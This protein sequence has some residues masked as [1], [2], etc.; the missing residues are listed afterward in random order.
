MPIN[1]DDHFANG[2]RTKKDEN[3][4]PMGSAPVQSATERR[5]RSLIAKLSGSAFTKEP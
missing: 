3:I 4:N 2:H 5:K 1:A